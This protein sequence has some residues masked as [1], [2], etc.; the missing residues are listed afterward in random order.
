MPFAQSCAFFAR[1]LAIG[2]NSLILCIIF[3]MPQRILCSDTQGSTLSR[4]PY[5]A[6]FWERAPLQT[7]QAL[8]PS[9][10]TGIQPIRK[11]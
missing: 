7:K 10:K 6:R 3:S 5:V 1:I 9:R 4:I 8:P 2:S 11:F